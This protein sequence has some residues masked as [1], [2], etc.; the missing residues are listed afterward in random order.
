MSAILS[1]SSSTY[2]P[3]LCSLFTI[4]HLTLTRP[5][6]SAAILADPRSRI[7][8]MLDADFRECVEA[9][10]QFP[11]MSLLGNQVNRGN[12]IYFG[13][14]PPPRIAPKAYI[15]AFSCMIHLWPRKTQAY[16]PGR[17]L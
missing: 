13:A 11:R 1:L 2:R 4:A 17:L 8:R 15:R 7:C 6:P 5:C 10:A 3:P 12:G 9:E 14:K 16:S